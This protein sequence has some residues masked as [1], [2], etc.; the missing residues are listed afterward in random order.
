MSGPDLQPPSQPPVTARCRFPFSPYGGLTS[1]TEEGRSFLQSRVALLWKVATL[2]ALGFL[3]ALGVSWLLARGLPLERI[4]RPLAFA[5]MAG[6]VVSLLA[7]QA[8]RRRAL[9]LLTIGLIDLT[10]GFALLATYAY[11]LATL[12]APPE[13]RTDLLM[14]ILTSAVI[15]VRAIVVPATVK[16]TALAAS[17]AVLP[18]LALSAFLFWT[19][20]LPA[21]HSSFAMAFMLAVL[22]CAIPVGLACLAGWVVYGLREQVA[23]ARRLGQYVLER[24][25]GEGGMGMVYLAQHALLRRPTAVKLLFPDRVGPEAIAR[26]ER[27][28]RLTAT[29]SHP[30]TV[31]I[32]DYGRAPDGAFYYAMEYL[33]GVDLDRLVSQHGPQPPSRVIHILQQVCASLAEAH[34]RGLVHRDIKPANI[35]LCERGGVPDTV[36][37]VDFGLVKDTA[38][39]AED[40][41]LSRANTIMGTPLYMPPETV[42]GASVDGRADLYSLGAVGYFLLTG[43]PVFDA[44]S[45]LEICS[46][47]LGAEP[48]TPSARLGTPLPADLEALVLACL[49]KDPA[50]RPGSAAELRR[51]L[52]ACAIAPWSE[53]SA[54]SWWAARPGAGPTSAPGALDATQP[55]EASAP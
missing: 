51:A 7:W 41:A 3:L 25:L 37:V 22:L 36:K 45:P 21:V 5:A 8:L 31:S 54:R 26:F 47:H 24:K 4:V 2:L 10:T 46:L 11:T 18:A 48:E 12:D 20:P 38:A 19:R 16:H 9:A 23:E 27:E 35:V 33:D 50:Q 6:L 34:G 43:K 53:D 28:V 55:M 39:R 52:L 42:R 40:S 32:F 17:V 49:R 13:M 15:T 30:N 29:L 14:I 44:A 1:T